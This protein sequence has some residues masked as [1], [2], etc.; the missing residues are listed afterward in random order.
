V[1]HHPFLID[2][3]D[4]CLNWIKG[5]MKFM[6]DNGYPADHENLKSW[7]LG[8]LYPTLTQFQ[9]DTCIR[10]FPEDDGYMMLEEMPGA[11]EGIQA[12][13]NHFRDSLFVAVTAS[14]TAPGVHHARRHQLRDFPFDTHILLPVHSNKR[15]V[16]EAFRSPIVI[17]DHVE[18]IVGA[19]PVAK[20]AILFEQNHNKWFH[21]TA[22]NYRRARSWT[23][24][25]RM[26][27]LGQE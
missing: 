3:D 1:S 10:R 14:G 20:L 22:S 9:I 18:Q 25:V 6:A 17:D 11:V 12:L 7:N 19:I 27:T 13:R 2:V 16:Y 15:K 23:E 21:E 4:V 24:I 26:L 5:F 8:H